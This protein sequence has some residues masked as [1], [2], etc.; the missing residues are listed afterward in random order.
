LIPCV[1]QGI[2]THEQWPAVHKWTFSNLAKDQELAERL[3]KCG[4]DDDGRSV[5]VKLKHFLQYV[6]YNHDDSPLYVFDTAFDED[7]LAKRILTE[8]NVPS[9]FQNDL[10]RYVKESRRPPYRWFLVGPE[11]SG[12]TI[13]IDPLATS[14]WNTLLVGKKRWVLFPPHVPKSIVKGKGLIAQHEDDEAIHYFTLILPRIRQKARAQRNDPQ[15]HNFACYEFTQHAGE[16]VFVPTGWWHAV[17]NI[18]H[19]IGCT[20]N[21]VS[22]ENFDSVWCQTRSGRK[23]MAWKWLQTLKEKEPYFYQRALALNKR[24]NFIMKYD[25]EHNHQL[26]HHDHHHH[27]NH[28]AVDSKDKKRKTTM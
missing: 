24:D 17:L 8:Y 27:N 18:T 25:P 6:Q 19:T 20:Q 2:P 1:I 3:F 14:A 5:K 15:Y 16:T 22:P 13:H 7:R 28:S 11:R 23:K 12:T 4:E 10:F 26:H 9:Y 21:F